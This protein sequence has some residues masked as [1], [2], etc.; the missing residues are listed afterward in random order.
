MNHNRSNDYDL[1][2]SPQRTP[3]STAL[4]N[5]DSIQSSPTSSISSSSSSSSSSLNDSYTIPDTNPKP[6]VNV[7]KTFPDSHLENNRPVTLHRSLSYNDSNKK[8]SNAN[9]TSTAAA[10]PYVMSLCKRS[11]SSMDVPKTS[12]YRID[13]IEEEKIPTTDNMDSN[14]EFYAIKLNNNT[15]LIGT[16]KNDNNSSSSDK[17]MKSIFRRCFNLLKY[18]IKTPIVL[19]LILIIFSMF[20]FLN[21]VIVSSNSI[22][23][24]MH[25]G[26]NINN[27]KN[28][29]TEYKDNNEEDNENIEETHITDIENEQNYDEIPIMSKFEH[30]GVYGQSLKQNPVYIDGFRTIPKNIFQ[31]S[32][33]M[34]EVSEGKFK[35]LNPDYY[36]R[37][38]SDEDADDLVK[39]N[40]PPKIY[41]AYKS[42]PKPVLRAD[43]FRYI[44]LYL[45]GGIYSDTDTVCQKSFDSWILA[46][47]DI[48][49]IAGLEL[50]QLE[51]DNWHHSS[52]ARQLQI[53]QWTLISRPY[54][55]IF[56]IVI[57]RIAEMTPRMNIL[58]PLLGEADRYRMILDWTGPGVYTDAVLDFISNKDIVDPARYYELHNFESV[59]N[60]ELIA[61]NLTIVRDKIVK[62]GTDVE[63]QELFAS[64]SRKI[65]KNTRIKSS[66]DNEFLQNLHNNLKDEKPYILKS[67]MI[68]P[69]YYLSPGANPTRDIHEEIS[70]SKVLHLFKGSWKGA[71]LW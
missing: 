24:E 22:N 71:S 33:N 1:L 70:D 6:K 21:S 10:R 31:T 59:E 48:Q 45:F 29:N 26:K 11:F 64:Y 55:P 50:D 63:S 46:D 13:T 68:A 37:M 49:L 40:F 66:Y 25:H 7:L 30:T 36:T 8:P 19:L 41:K 18:I 39:R 67:V 69:R 15:N 65:Y 43:Y 23:N 4:L 5:Q 52:Y 2:H 58:F 62:N 35:S 54:H 32:K 57:D 9:S 28:H 17:R 47:S 42:M 16:D 38:F 12:Y 27:I 56:G 44:V 53:L 61:K 20:I 51:N 3:S 60:I 34:K 14:N